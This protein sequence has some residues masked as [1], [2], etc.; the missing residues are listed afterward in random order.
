MKT[1][2]QFFDDHF[3]YEKKKKKEEDEDLE[4]LFAQSGDDEDD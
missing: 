4:S 1:Y 2:K 3:L